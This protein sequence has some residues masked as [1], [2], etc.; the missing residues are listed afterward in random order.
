MRVPEIPIF[1]RHI[2]PALERRLAGS[3]MAGHTGTL[4]IN[5]YRSRFVLR[6]EGGRLVEVVEGF[7]YNRLE[8]GDASFPD[9]T[10]LQLL[11]GHRSIDTLILAHTDL[12][13]EN[14]EARVLLRALFPKQ[15]SRTI[16]LG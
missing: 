10:F 9:L 1:L 7:E 15:S 6:W 12:F 2:T 5:L 4:K 11:F 16:P 8:E 14:N 13:V 3:V